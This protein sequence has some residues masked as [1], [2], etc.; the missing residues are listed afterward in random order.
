MKLAAVSEIREMYSLARTMNFMETDT[1]WTAGKIS[2]VHTCTMLQLNSVSSLQPITWRA[3]VSG[4]GAATPAVTFNPPITT[5]SMSMN[6]SRKAA[7]RS[8][9]ALRLRGR[10]RKPILEPDCDTLL[11]IVRCCAALRPT[12]STWPHSS[13]STTSAWVLLPRR[14]NGHLFATRLNLKLLFIN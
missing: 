2:L 8:G 5:T 3:K 10:S 14:M 1:Y 4:R 9:R 6:R 11:S 7:R 13:V 12:C